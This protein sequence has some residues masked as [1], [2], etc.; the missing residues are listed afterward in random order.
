MK[1]VEKRQNVFTL[2]ADPADGA[3]D[4]ARAAHADDISALSQGNLSS[5]T[6]A[7]IVLHLA[8]RLAALEGKGC[9]TR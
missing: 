4:E 5:E 7:G 8:Q 1:P 6:L 9:T 3:A 2:V